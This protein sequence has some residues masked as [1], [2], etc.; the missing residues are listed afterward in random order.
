MPQRPSMNML[1]RP[2]DPLHSTI[3][4][5]HSSAKTTAPNLSA[6]FGFA[7]MT[8]LRRFLLKPMVGAVPGRDREARQGRPSRERPEP[9]PR[10]LFGLLRLDFAVS[11][12]CM[13]VERGE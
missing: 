6:M 2:W 12:R 10:P 11:R 5:V 1:T 13:C 8:G 4:A 7:V 9:Q 3:H